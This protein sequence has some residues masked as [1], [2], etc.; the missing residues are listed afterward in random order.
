MCL[1]L[2][3]LND[4]PHY[5]L[6][7][8]ANRDEFYDRPTAAANFWEDHLSVLGG[9]DLKHG[10]TWLGISKTGRIAALTNFRNPSN[11]KSH[12]LSRGQLVSDF[13]KYQFKPVEYYQ[14]LTAT[15]HKYND[16]SLLFG[17]PGQMYFMSSHFDKLQSL[18]PGIY[19]L[20]NH[21]LNTPWPK[22]KIGLDGLRQ[23]LANN[24]KLRPDAIFEILTDRT[25]PDDKFLPD[26]GVGLEWERILAPVFITSSVY[27]TRSS[28]VLLIDLE[29][30]V[31]FTE[32]IYH[33][34][35]PQDFTEQKFEFK[36]NHSPLSPS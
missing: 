12:A 29:N 2:F 19:G 31:N 27:G 21:L 7:L 30:N 1:I 33:D 32:R 23:L 22:V 4:H 3:S 24:D 17:N 8:A 5:Q 36:L 15:R 6:V 34:H 13:L 35:D 25:R 10:G 28:T 16:F 20:S 9:R 18:T 11:R 26:T 14:I